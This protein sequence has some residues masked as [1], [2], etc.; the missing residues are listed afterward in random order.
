MCLAKAYLRSI[1]PAAKDDDLLMESVSRIDVEN[2]SVKLTSLFG[3]IKELQA[4]VLSISFT[5]SRVVLGSPL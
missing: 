5:E 3:D 1:T 2:G 4:Q